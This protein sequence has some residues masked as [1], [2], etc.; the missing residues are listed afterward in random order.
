MRWALLIILF[1]FSSIFAQ[2]DYEIKSLR[3]FQINDET[4]F[5]VSIYGSKLTIEFDLKCDDLP[6]WEIKFMLCD[7]N[8]EPY[9]SGLLIDEIYNTERNLW[10]ENLPFRSES[11]DYHYVNSFP[12]ENVKFPFSGKWMFF[13]RDSY[14]PDV[15]YGEGKFYVVNET[16]TNLKTSL[17][18]NR[19]HGKNIVPAVF[20]EIFDLQVSVTVPESL[21]VDKVDC[22]ELIENRKIE[23]PILIDKSYDDEF[24]YYEI[25]SYNSYSFFVKNIQPGSAYRQVDLMNKTKH[26][27]PKTFA[28]FDGIEISNKFRPGSNDYL[29][30]SKIMNYKNVNSEY[31]DVEFR[32]RPPEEY[33]ENIFLVGAF[34]NW[35]IY[36]DFQLI[37][38]DGIYS[39]NVE[40]KRGVYDYQYVVANVE[41]NYLTNIDWI[42]LEGNSWST[43][44]EYNIFLFYKTDE[45]GGYD[46]I[47]AYKKIRSGN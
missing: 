29:G 10:F 25:D 6:N 24:K 21:F 3:I 16:A 35:D 46:K 26:Q 12:N 33:Y 36:P 45:L 17:E 40:L 13:I 37:E 1:S 15:I 38:K 2:D 23:Y 14:E 44:R 9:D 22:V 31:L 39:A 20:G 43:V 5:P 32:L 4:S 7:K 41:N 34:T 47:I 28:H 30:G 27:A 11:A 42:E 8:W 19:M 18:Q